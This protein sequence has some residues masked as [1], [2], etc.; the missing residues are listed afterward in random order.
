MVL[1]VNPKPRGVSVPTFHPQRR[2]FMK[3][4]ICRD[5]NQYKGEMNKGVTVVWML[6]AKRRDV[7]IVMS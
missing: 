2:L 6:S 7:V 3:F 4:V 5:G 1:R